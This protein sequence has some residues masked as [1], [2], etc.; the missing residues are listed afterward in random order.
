MRE[1][2]FVILGLRKLK[3]FSALAKVDPRIL[4]FPPKILGSSAASTLA[5][6]SVASPRMTGA[7]L[8][9]TISLSMAIFSILV[10]STA[11]A[12]SVDL[13]SGGKD[14][15]LVIE[16]ADTFTILSEENTMT[17]QGNVVATRG[18]VVLHCDQLTAYYKRQEDNHPADDTKGGLEKVVAEGHVIITN[19]ET[20]GF[21]DVAVYDVPE[22]HV[23]LTGQDLKI[24]GPDYVLTAQDSFD[25]FRQENVAVATGNARFKK[26]NQVVQSDTLRASFQPGEEGKLAL[27]DIVATAHVVIVT[28]DQTITAN[29]GKYRADADTAYLFGEV[30]MTQGENQLYGQYGE[31]SRKTGL[32]KIFPH[33]PEGGGADL[34]RVQVRV[35]PNKSKDLKKMRDE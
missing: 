10:F 9:S 34:K 31:Y 2:F 30:K 20:Q 27:H 29:H 1:N 35:I 33:N 24:V 14:T 5:A 26:E 3:R 12:Q 8:H 32:G 13:G 18:D 17:A 16:A 22:D 15:P 19:A 25:Y 23:V 7:F 4:T 11:Y 28:D 6:W 21:G